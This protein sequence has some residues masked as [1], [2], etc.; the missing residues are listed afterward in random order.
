MDLPQQSSIDVVSMA[1]AM[2]WSVKKYSHDENKNNNQAL[3]S[4]LAHF[5]NVN[6]NKSSFKMK[7]DIAWHL[8]TRAHFKSTYNPFLSTKKLRRF[9]IMN[10]LYEYLEFIQKHEFSDESYVRED[11]LWR[12]E[13]SSKHRK[14]AMSSHN[15]SMNRSPSQPKVLLFKT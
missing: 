9:F 8:Q 15:F 1:N 5:Y 12:V 11:N 3:A 7:P 10:L 2:S 4:Y 6:G 13:F 14:F